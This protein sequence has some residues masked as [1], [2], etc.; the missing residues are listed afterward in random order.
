MWVCVSHG[1]L[2][3]GRGEDSGAWGVETDNYGVH[4]YRAVHQPIDLLSG[5]HCPSG[6][7]N[8]YSL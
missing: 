1:D 4:V 8:Q 6:G 2:E 3:A 7:H 5:Q